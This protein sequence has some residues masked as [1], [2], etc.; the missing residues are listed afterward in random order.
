MQ[1]PIVIG[2]VLL[3]L[4]G[5]PLIT[6]ALL[7]FVSLG[8]DGPGDERPEPPTPNHPERSIPGKE[9]DL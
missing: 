9:S 5:A 8:S 1:D 3:G 4:L 7:W 6:Y 2:A